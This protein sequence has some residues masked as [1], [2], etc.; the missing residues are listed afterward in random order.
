MKRPN[1]WIVLIFIVALIGG[2]AWYMENHL[3]EDQISQEVKN[4]LQ[5]QLVKAI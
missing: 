2:G 4:G 3:T 1:R 5:Q